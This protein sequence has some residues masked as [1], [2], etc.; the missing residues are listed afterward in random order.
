MNNTKKEFDKN[1]KLR[2]PDPITKAPGSHPIGTGIGAVAGGAAAGAA[3]GT[4]A[5]PVGMIAGAAVGAVV[6]GLAGK[7]VAEVVNPT[8]EDAYWR[9]NHSRQPYAKGRSYDDYGPAYRTG[10]EG[11]ALY[12]AKGGTFEDREVELRRSYEVT[13]PKL[14]WNEARPASRAAWQRFRDQRP[15][16]SKTA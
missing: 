2:N 4:V 14:A 11:Y 9:E 7:G 16:G 8:V 15:K 13:Q 1:D 6:G 3:V 5:G 12:G 10:Y